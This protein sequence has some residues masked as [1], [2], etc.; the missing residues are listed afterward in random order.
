MAEIRDD[1]RYTREHE[2]ASLG[3]DGLV[4]IGID[5]YAQAAMGD[6]VMVELPES[7]DTVSAGEEFGSVESPKSVSDLFAPLGGEITAVN[8]ALEDAPELVNESC[9]EDGWIVKIRP[10]DADEFLSLMD[11]A[12]Y[13]TY[14]E[15]LE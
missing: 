3:E 6:I 9:Y 8:E 13:R 2:W 4:T 14:L 12:A 10:G 7:G 11:A 15:T 5:D 1:L